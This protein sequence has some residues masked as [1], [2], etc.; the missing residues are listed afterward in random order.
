MTRMFVPVGRDN[1]GWS[2]QWSDSPREPAA[3]FS[4]TL[5]TQSVELDVV[6]GLGSSLW[7]HVSLFPDLH[8]TNVKIGRLSQ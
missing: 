6:E 7:S 8:V 5:R 4:E 2:N 1:G 3:T